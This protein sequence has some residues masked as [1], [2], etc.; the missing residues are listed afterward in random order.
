MLIFYILVWSVWSVDKKFLCVL[1]RSTN[2]SV[3]SECHRDWSL[4]SWLSILTAYSITVFRKGKIGFGFLKHEGWFLF[5]GQRQ[6]TP[7][8]TVWQLTVCGKTRMNM[9]L[10]KV[11]RKSCKTGER[12]CFRGLFHSSRYCLGSSSSTN[13]INIRTILSSII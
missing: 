4:T 10:F 13:G 7:G 11:T 2:V 12:Y 9:D 1:F 3:S 6:F 5:L 8:V